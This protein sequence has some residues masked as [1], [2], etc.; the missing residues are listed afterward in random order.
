[1]KYLN[2]LNLIPGVGSQKIKM[3][4][5]FFGSPEK[6]WQADR[7]DLLNSG[8]G[9]NL[10][11]TIIERRPSINPDKEWDNLLKENIRL[12]TVQDPLYPRL[13]KEIP[14]PPYALYVKSAED[15]FDFNSQ[16]MIAIVGSRKFTSYGKQTAE[17]MAAEIAQSGIAVVSGMAIGIDAFAHRGALNGH[18]KTVAVLASSLEDE[19]IGPRH[20]FN[21][22]REIIS[23]GALVSDFAPGTVSTPGNFPARNR[24]MAGM[25]LGTLVVEAAVESGSLITANLALEFNRE[26]FAVPGS[27]YSPQSEGC[28]QLLRSGAKV[29]TGVKDILEEL[30][31]EE[32]IANEL[33]RTDIPA[34]P[35]EEKILKIITREPVHIDTLAKKVKLE[36]SIVSGTLAVMELK[37]MVKNIG[38]QNYILL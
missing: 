28:H 29:V 34:T 16:P 19:I 27:I 13:L 9:E 11:Q 18:G 10:T 3:L 25:T 14:N 21:L 17:K 2:A 4:L 38:G 7:T 12:I 32:K 8:I 35:E 36:T 20:N 1:M 26:V 6:A 22:S 33:A 5:D 30:R 23:A 24:L 37:G 15:Y 31:I